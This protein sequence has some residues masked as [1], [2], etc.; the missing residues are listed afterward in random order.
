M[1]DLKRLCLLGGLLVAAACATSA[2]DPAPVA[3]ADGEA[4]KTR[5]ILISIDGFRTDYLDLGVTPVMSGLA[6]EGARGSMRPSFPSKTFPNHYSLITG[7]R[8]DHHGVINNTMEDP[9]KP[10]VVFE[11]W[12][13]EVAS[14][15]DWWEGGTPLWVSAEK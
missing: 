7:L 11:I 1:I 3:N 13:R 4:A 12:N 6:E 8:P 15:P 10:G 9:G 5:T 14:D 2:D